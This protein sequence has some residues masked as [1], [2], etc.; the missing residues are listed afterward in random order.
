ME[1]I[2]ALKSSKARMMLVDLSLEMTSTY[3]N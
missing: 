1:G 2:M 3:P